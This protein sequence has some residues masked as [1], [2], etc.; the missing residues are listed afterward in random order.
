MKRLNTGLLLLAAGL[1]LLQG[2]TGPQQR[3][4][5][6]PVEE[7]SI[8]GD[9]QAAAEA[10]AEGA[11]G[12]ES[13]AMAMAGEFSVEALNNPDS[14]LSKRVFYFAYDSSDLS[15]ED[16]QRLAA[17]AQFISLHPDIS[18]VVEG[19]ADERGTREYNLAL[20]ERRARAVERLI[21]VQ[22][23]SREQLQVIGFGEERPV[24][25]GRDEASWRLNRRVE[26]LYS[27]Y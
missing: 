12:A 7:R 8:N 13:T 19:H 14:P 23:A 9:Q 17:H 4:E 3:P 6:V 22:G 2:C 5:D 26:L 15:P 24:A 11:A 27:G 20:S 16:Q 21:S 10:E 18:V 1:L 25:L